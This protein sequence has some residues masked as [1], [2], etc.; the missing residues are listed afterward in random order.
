MKLSRT[1]LVWR[2]F[3]G[4]LNE[5]RVVDPTFISELA[6]ELP[7]L[8]D[9]QV[10]ERTA[11]SL[12]PEVFLHTAGMDRPP[13]RAVAAEPENADVLLLTMEPVA[14][15]YGYDDAFAVASPPPAVRPRSTRQCVSAPLEQ[16]GIAAGCGLPQHVYE[17]LWCE[18]IGVRPHKGLALR[19]P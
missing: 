11:E 7:S 17:G 9:A 8:V 16:G 19:R 14:L 15:R 12:L 3:F 6:R 5:S 1:P 13:H 18:A 10:L 4:Q 2:G